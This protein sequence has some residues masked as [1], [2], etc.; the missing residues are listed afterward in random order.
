MQDIGGVRC[1]HICGDWAGG[2]CAACTRSCVL[3]ICAASRI[4]C[5]AWS[6]S[7][8]GWRPKCIGAVLLGR[9]YG[10]RCPVWRWRRHWRCGKAQR[11]PSHSRIGARWHGVC[12]R[13]RARARCGACARSK[14]LARWRRSS[15]G[16]CCGRWSSRWARPGW[17]MRSCWPMAGVAPCWRRRGCWWRRW[18]C[19]VGHG[20]PGRREPASILHATRC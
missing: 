6:H 18:G 4:C 13:W 8:Y 1:W 2:R 14:A 7:V 15:S 10:R 16:G 17:P 11:T 12:L 20:W 19:C 5:W 3:P 9:W